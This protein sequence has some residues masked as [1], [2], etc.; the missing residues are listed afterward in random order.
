MNDYC[1]L[2]RIN[3][4]MALLDPPF[5]F[6]CQAEDSDHAEEQ[7]IN[8]YPDCDVVWIEKTKSYQDAMEFYY[9]INS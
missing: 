5:G 6:I 1:V 8:A 4:V 7:C 2:Y 3:S 9:D